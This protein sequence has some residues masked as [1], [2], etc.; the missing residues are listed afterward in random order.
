M[1]GGLAA[2]FIAAGTGA[3]IG[4]AGAAVI[5]SGAGAAII[6]SAFG[7][8]GAGLIGFRMK[9]RVGGLEQFEFEPLFMEGLAEAGAR[10]GGVGGGGAGG[11]GTVGAGGVGGGGA[12]E[13]VES[14]HVGI[15]ISGWLNSDADDSFKMPWVNLMLSKEQYAL[16]WEGTRSAAYGP[17]IFNM[18]HVLYVNKLNVCAPSPTGKYLLELGQSLEY[19]LHVAMQKAGIEALKYTVLSGVM[20]AVAWPVGILA[21]S[22]AIDN[23]W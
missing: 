20:S 17:Y 13:G 11:V 18:L 5:G 21:L 3:I 19:L 6:G 8:G 7:V 10:A 2:P 23:P 1:T 15:A 9:R 14:L 22:H 16:K 4:T 12:I